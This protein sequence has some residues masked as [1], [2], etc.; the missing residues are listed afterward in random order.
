MSRPAH[1]CER[2][3]HVEPAAIL[4]DEVGTQYTLEDHAARSTLPDRDR[5]VDAD[6][7]VADPQV[8][9]HARPPS[10]G[11]RRG[12]LRA[13]RRTAR[14]VHR[15]SAPWRA[16]RGRARPR[17][18]ESRCAARRA[19]GAPAR[20]RAPPAAR[21]SHQRRA[22]VARRVPPPGPARQG[23][24]RTPRARTR[25]PTNSGAPDARRR[26]ART[27]LPEGSGGTA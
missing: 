14:C 7:W 9:M 21:T 2:H 3:V 24:S 10:A 4:E 27:P 12:A 19:R 13:D 20:S 16:P 15:P 25:G 5:E 1:S 26:P 8:R 11:S 18:P 6:R 23:C 22:E 17:V